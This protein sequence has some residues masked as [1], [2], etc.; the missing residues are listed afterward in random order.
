M[1]STLVF[2]KSRELGQGGCF[3]GALQADQ[4]DLDGRLDLEVELARLPAHHLAQ[5]VGDKPDQ[6]LFGR[7]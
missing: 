4:H 6:M 1:A 5:L 2:Q 7:E 3:A